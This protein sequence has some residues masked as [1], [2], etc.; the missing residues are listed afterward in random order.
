MTRKGHCP[1]WLLLKKK[2]SFVVTASV[3]PVMTRVSGAPRREGWK[4]AN[5]VKGWPPAVTSH[6]P[7]QFRVLHKA[8]LQSHLI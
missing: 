6:Q 5:V 4:G 1:P 2:V 3:G 8:E 7:S